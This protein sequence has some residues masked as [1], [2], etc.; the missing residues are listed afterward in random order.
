MSR[1]LFNFNLALEGV[2]MNKLRALLT[3]LGILFGV[4]SVIA[5]LSIGTGAKES[6]LEQMKLIGANSVVVESKVLT[7]EEE[8]EE[9]TS[10]SENNDKEGKKKWSPGLT[11][12]DVEAIRKILPTIEKTSPELILDV[13]VLGNAKQGETKCIG[14]ENDFFEL[15]NIVLGEGKLFAPYHHENGSPVCIIGRNIQTKYFEQRN[16]IGEKIRCNNT[17]LTIIGVLN[18]RIASRENRESLGIRDYNSDIYIPLQTALI[19][20]EDRAKIAR[21]D[22]GRRRGNNNANENYHQLDRLVVRVHETDQ[23]QASADVV[24]RILKR[25]HREKN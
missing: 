9:G 19:R 11:I 5:M 22:I 14:I 25:R 10:G 15:N 1:L 23:L 4:A 12:Q 2:F 20:F 18:K 8:E 17:W 7:G 3:T 16:P 21:N 24:A 13:T 6:I